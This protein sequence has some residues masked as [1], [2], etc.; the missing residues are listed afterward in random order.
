MTDLYFFDSGR[1]LMGLSIAL[2]PVWEDWRPTLQRT[3]ASDGESRVV[4]AS[5][6]LLGVVPPRSVASTA[7]TAVSVLVVISVAMV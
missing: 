6:S 3:V 2:T 1:M 5:P 7:A 4:A